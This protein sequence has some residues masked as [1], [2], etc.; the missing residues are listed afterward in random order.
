MPPLMQWFHK[1]ADAKRS[2][3][4]VPDEAWDDWLGTGDEDDARTFLTLPNPQELTAE[5]DPRGK[6]SV[7][8]N[9]GL[10]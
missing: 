7:P 8:A 1:P 6:M 10:F 4:M 5:A 9:P 3:V 2:V